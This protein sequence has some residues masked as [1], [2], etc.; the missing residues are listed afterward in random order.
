M[1]ERGR[2]HAPTRDE[3][4]KWGVS[5]ANTMKEDESTH[6][7]EMRQGGHEYGEYR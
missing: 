2:M 7:L 4:R 3:E 5:T 6:S 1:D